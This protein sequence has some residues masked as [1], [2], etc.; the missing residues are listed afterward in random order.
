MIE[1]ESGPDATIVC[2]P[3]G[4]LD[5]SSAVVLRHVITDLLQAGVRIV[6]DLRHVNSIDAVGVRALVGSVRRVRAFG[7]TAHVS[8]T[9]RR[10]AYLL[11]LAGAHRLVAPAATP[12][13]GAA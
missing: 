13:P 2:R 11:A 3:A 7:G 8:N 10:V 6:V 12:V 4:N 5:P 9:N 1:I